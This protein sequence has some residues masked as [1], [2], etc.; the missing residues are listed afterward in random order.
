MKAVRTLS[1]IGLVL[2]LAA[3][4]RLTVENYGKI[5]NGMSY[6]EVKAIIGAPTKCSE[7][8]GIRICTW[9]DDKRFINVNFVADKV[10]LTAADNLN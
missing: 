4:N 3:C 6:D 10:V 7:A 1:L 9:G 2:L 8:L 5:Q